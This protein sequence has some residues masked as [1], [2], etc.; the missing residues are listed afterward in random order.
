MVKFINF[1]LLL[2]TLFTFSLSLPV[3]KSDEFDLDSTRFNEDYYTIYIDE[4]TLNKRSEG[5]TVES[6]IKDIN[7]IIKDGRSL[8]K[9]KNKLKE[10]EKKYEE[11]QLMKRDTSS[12]DETGYAFPLYSNNGHP[13]VYTYL[14]PGLLEEID[15]LPYVDTIEPEAKIEFSAKPENI[16][17]ILKETGWKDL[18][19][20]ES[21]YHL[22]LLSQDASD[23]GDDY[24][25]NYYYPSTAGKDV[26][27]YLFEAGYNFNNTE[28]RST[29]E[30]RTFKC[31][32]TSID[33]VELVDGSKCPKNND[34]YYNFHGEFVS[35][36]AGGRKHGV[37]RKANIYGTLIENNSIPFINAALLYIKDNLLRPNKS[38]FNFS[39]IR[40]TSIIEHDFKE[41]RSIQKLQNII[42]EMTEADGIFIAS[43][44]D[45]G[46]P[47]KYI[48]KNI[49][50]VPCGLENVICVGGV[51]NRYQSSLIEKKN[52]KVYYWRAEKSNYGEYVDLY[53]PSVAEIG[54][55]DKDKKN[56]KE[57]IEGTLPL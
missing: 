22:S 19:Y 17:K 2:S 42:N 52:D 8:Y 36:I 25:N 28:F 37:A 16:E 39:F 49:R 46:F 27:I 14:H 44:G 48:Y 4:K 53:A 55:I 50:V 1:T 38:V 34:D 11:N 56:V 41:Y 57:V 13:V 20:E 23:A 30:D 5:S 15:S 32:N 45:Y 35:T 31:I 29:N 7:Q 40:W 26:D 12:S 51:D 6:A 33:G 24:D 3:A 43:S 18:T 10:L 9:N 47:T 54:Y 21:Q